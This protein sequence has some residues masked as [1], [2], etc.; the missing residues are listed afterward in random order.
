MHDFLNSVFCSAENPLRSLLVRN[1][2]AQEQVIC[3]YFR[4]SMWNDFDECW[5]VNA[6]AR[7]QF[8]YASHLYTPGSSS[9]GCGIIETCTASRI[10][11]IQLGRAGAGGGERYFSAVSR[12]RGGS[13][14][15][16][17]KLST[18]GSL[19]TTVVELFSDIAEEHPAAVI[20]DIRF[21]GVA[22]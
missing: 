4:S 7:P 5:F 11:P 3:A 15:H 13:W 14:V 1:V 8:L 9:I 18:R 20:A 16:K 19:N 2:F 22:R 6:T 17:K 21:D 12:A 10:K